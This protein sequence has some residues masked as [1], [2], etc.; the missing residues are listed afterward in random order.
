MTGIIV[1]AFIAVLAVVVYTVAQT[2]ERINESTNERIR[3]Q[4]YA[5]STRIERPY[6]DHERK[7]FSFR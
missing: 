4:S 7:L 5:G 3:H 1:V 6:T 2:V